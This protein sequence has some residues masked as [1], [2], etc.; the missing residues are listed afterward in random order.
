MI[1]TE[2]PILTAADLDCL[3]AGERSSYRQRL[4]PWCVI[5]LLP[6]MQRA[7]VSRTRQR[8]VAEHYLSLLQRLHPKASY[9]LIFDPMG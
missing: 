8:N 5:R 9:I 4:H 7:V 2:L 3:N 6:N 1:P